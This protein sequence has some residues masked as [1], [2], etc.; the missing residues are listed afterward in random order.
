MSSAPLHV[1][2]SLPPMSPAR[3]WIE[4]TGAVIVEGDGESDVVVFD[5]RRDDAIHACDAPRLAVLPLDGTRGV[6]A[7]PEAEA[8][9]NIR[10]DAYAGD[11]HGLAA[12][13]TY[14]ASPRPDPSAGPLR[15]TYLGGLGAARTRAEPGTSVPMDRRRIIGRGKTCDLILRQGPHS[16]QNI[17]ARIHTVVERKGEE[18]VVEDAQSTNGTW[19]E[20]RRIEGA[21]SLRPGTELVVSWC[22][23]VRLDGTG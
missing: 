15:L 12:A 4:R 19:I 17:V 20:G 16:D 8:F 10:A 6:P 2:V 14:L 3:A 9:V 22:F 11:E 23:R 7:N 13:L 5:P 21:V 18:V 1:L